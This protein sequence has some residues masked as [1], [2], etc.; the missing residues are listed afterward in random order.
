M[1]ALT[2][3]C[4]NP[5]PKEFSYLKEFFLNTCPYHFHSSIEYH[6]P[7]SLPAQMIIFLGD[8]VTFFYRVQNLLQFPHHVHLNPNVIVIIIRSLCFL[9]TCSW[10]IVV[11]FL[12]AWENIMTVIVISNDRC[13]QGGRNGW[14]YIFFVT[15]SALTSSFFYKSI[16]ILLSL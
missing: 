8:W 10:M 13:T 5:L 16:F 2:A 3:I 14:W 7:T 6:Q 4:N 12:F 1:Y 11:K 9:C 15:G